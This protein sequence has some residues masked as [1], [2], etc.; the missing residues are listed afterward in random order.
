MCPADVVAMKQGPV[1][2]VY[3]RE[4]ARGKESKRNRERQEIPEECKYMRGRKKG[5]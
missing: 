3:M 1:L 5:N 4:S 2:C